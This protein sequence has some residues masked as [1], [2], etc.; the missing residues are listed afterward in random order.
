MVYGQNA[1][2]CDPLMKYW[3][4][5]SGAKTFIITYFA[6]DD[7]SGVLIVSFPPTLELRTF[8]EP[9]EASPVPILVGSTSFEVCTLLSTASSF[10][11]SCVPRL[12]ISWQAEFRRNHI[13]QGFQ[14][15]VFHFI[16]RVSTGVLVE[17]WET[18][19]EVHCLVSV[20]IRSKSVRL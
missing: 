12:T 2:S 13:I 19:L 20:F 8:L 11:I 1:H 17:K 16:C 5:D 15:I 18:K 3:T 9:P 10:G 6:T 4:L 14:D 7:V